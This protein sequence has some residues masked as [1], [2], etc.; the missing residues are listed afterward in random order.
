MILFMW[1]KSMS[2][3]IEVEV[4]FAMPERQYLV[5]LQLAAGVSVA[6]AIAAARPQL[7][8][9]LPELEG[10]TGIFSKMVSLET[11]LS[12]GDRVEIYRPLLLDP[13]D[14]RRARAK[15]SPIKKLRGTP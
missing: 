4:A 2:D 14:Q 15:A 3:L 13:M 5:S 1:Q 12:P 9:H 11:K 6:E 10:N 7:P 8:D